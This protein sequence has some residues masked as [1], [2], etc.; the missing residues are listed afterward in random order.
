[1]DEKLI[2]R[3]CDPPGSQWEKQGKKKT[4]GNVVTHGRGIQR[5]L[6]NLT[7]PI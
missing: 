1:M 2:S 5:V 4:G 6:L 7:F 3:A